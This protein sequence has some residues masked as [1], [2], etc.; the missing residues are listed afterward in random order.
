MSAGG[1]VVQPGALCQAKNRSPGPLYGGG[2]PPPP[3]GAPTAPKENF[4]LVGK[5][6]AS[7]PPGWRSEGST[8]PTPNP[9]THTVSR[10]P[11]QPGAEH[12]RPHEKKSKAARHVWGQGSLTPAVN[13][14]F[15]EKE[16]ALTAVL[17]W[18]E[19]AVSCSETHSAAHRGSAATPPEWQPERGPRPD[20][21]MAG[22]RRA[23]GGTPTHGL[24]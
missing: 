13:G 12:R 24:A 15:R 6:G 8:P 11:E 5:I 20:G 16:G 18:G 2:C 17:C 10:N 9:T 3:G 21:G 22:E 23:P 4:D 1:G 19:G 14:T 7:P